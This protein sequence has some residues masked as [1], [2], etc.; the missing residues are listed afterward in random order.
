MVSSFQIKLQYNGSNNQGNIKI[1]QNLVYEILI[2]IE[3][4]GV[5]KLIIS[6]F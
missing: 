1:F 3:F 4:N 2:L 6:D 5:F